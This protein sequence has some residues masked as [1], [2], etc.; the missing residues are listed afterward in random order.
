MGGE[1]PAILAS[2]GGRAWWLEAP[3]QNLYGRPPIALP[4]WVTLRSDINYRSP[5]DILERLNRLLP[6]QHPLQAGS[7]LTGSDVDIVSYNDTADMIAKTVDAVKQCVGLG[8]KRS[9][10]ALITYHGRESSR[11][12]PYTKLGT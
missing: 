9:H 3:M 7:P 10:I 5:K 11:L 12:T 2:G 8:F 4:G 1:P 6:L